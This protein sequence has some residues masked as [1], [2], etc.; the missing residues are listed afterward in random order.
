MSN[1][2]THTHTEKFIGFHPF[3]CTSRKSGCADLCFHLNTLS[4]SHTLRR[5]TL[6][7]AHP[8]DIPLCRPVDSSKLPGRLPAPH[9]GVILAETSYTPWAIASEGWTSITRG[10]TPSQPE[11]WAQ[12]LSPRLAPIAGLAFTRHQFWNRAVA[13]PAPPGT[14]CV[15]SRWARAASQSRNWT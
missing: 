11:N 1:A 14:T 15:L 5:S 8:G 9:P 2:H 6:V 12:L 3:H 4:L 7:T 10:R 13:L